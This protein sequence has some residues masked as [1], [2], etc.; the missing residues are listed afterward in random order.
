[1]KREG[2]KKNQELRHR[3]G[4]TSILTVA[5]ATLPLELRQSRFWRRKNE[6]RTRVWKKSHHAEGNGA[7]KKRMKTELES[8]EENKKTDVVVMSAEERC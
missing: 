1:M 7:E 8:G 4:L 6:T 2:N 5:K 3:R